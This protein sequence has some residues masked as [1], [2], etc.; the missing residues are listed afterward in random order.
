LSRATL[1][2]SGEASS[3]HGG[4]LI[5]MRGGVTT[6]RG[7]VRKAVGAPERGRLRYVLIHGNGPRSRAVRRD[8][9]YTP[10]LGRGDARRGNALGWQSRYRCNSV[11]ERDLSLLNSYANL[12]L[13]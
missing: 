6:A 2:G 10:R 7:N 13:G 8:E 5:P 9:G 12:L 1:A 3:R 11:N 4:E